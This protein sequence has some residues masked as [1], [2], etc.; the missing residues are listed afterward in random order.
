VWRYPLFEARAS[1]RITRA[2]LA[3]NIVIATMSRLPFTGKQNK[4]VLGEKTDKGS[5]DCADK[6]R[7]DC[8]IPSRLEHVDMCFDALTPGG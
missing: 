5:D 2:F 1:I 3:G 6:G 7:G 4:E 8:I